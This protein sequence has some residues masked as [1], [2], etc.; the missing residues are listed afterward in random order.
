MDNKNTLPVNIRKAMDVI[1]R[2]EQEEILRI[3]AN[4]IEIKCETEWF[5]MSTQD[6]HS[7]FKKMKYN[8]NKTAA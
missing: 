3:V 6:A 8:E 7:F 5:F 1:T 4:G 2:L